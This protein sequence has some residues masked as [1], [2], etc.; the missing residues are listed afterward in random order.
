MA[1][2]IGGG[3]HGNV[4]QSIRPSTIERATGVKL[5]FGKSLLTPP[6]VALHPHDH[7][8]AIGN[9]TRISQRECCVSARNPYIAASFLQHACISAFRITASS[10]LK[11]NQ[12]KTCCRS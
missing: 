2:E 1:S 3:M 12:I 10:R 4:L 11:R 7:M 9:L 6:L 8:I 5:F